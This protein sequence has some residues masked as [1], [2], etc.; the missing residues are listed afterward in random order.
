MLSKNSEEEVQNFFRKQFYIDHKFLSQNMHITVYHSRRPMFNLEELTINCN[1]NTD[2][3]DTRFMVLAPGGENPKPDL[4]PGER[5]VG[6]RFK[7][8]TELRNQINIYREEIIKYEDKYVLGNRKQSNTK[9]NAFGSRYFQP[10]MTILQ[11]GSGIITDLTIVGEEFRELI[12]E[13]NFNK[14]IIKRR[15]LR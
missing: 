2:T 9:R 1:H 10:H 15:K 8:G 7:K 14:Y 4:I 13:L 12:H 11:S 6:I 5:K 3:K